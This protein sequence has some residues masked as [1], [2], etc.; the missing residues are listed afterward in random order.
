MKQ[1][2]DAAQYLEDTNFTNYHEFPKPFSNS[3]KLVKFVSS[4]HRSDVGG[5][6]QFE[7]NFP[8]ST[9]FKER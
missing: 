3:C 2:N 7:S 1:L 6:V 4:Q 5:R 8:T 9:V